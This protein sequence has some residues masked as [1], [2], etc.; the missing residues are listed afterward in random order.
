[1]HIELPNNNS[2]DNFLVPASRILYVISRKKW[3][4]LGKLLYLLNLCNIIINYKRVGFS[5]MYR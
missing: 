3:K 5:H 1:M 4:L 2:A